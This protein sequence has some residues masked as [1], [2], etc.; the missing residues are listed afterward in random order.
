MK[1]KIKHLDG[2]SYTL[3]IIGIEFN[4]NFIYLLK[5]YFIAILISICQ[6]LEAIV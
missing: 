3:F 4:L 2:L 1:Y 5:T 6:V